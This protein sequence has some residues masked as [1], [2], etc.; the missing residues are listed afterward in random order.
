M[1]QYTYQN[2]TLS[3]ELKRTRRKNL[4]VYVYPGRRV[5]LRVP[6]AA[7]QRHIE[8]YLQQSGAWIF[9][10]LDQLDAEGAGEVEV[11]SFAQGSQHFLHGQPYALEL[12][13]AARPQRIVRVGN[14][15][16]VFSLNPEEPQRTQALLKSWYKTQA[17]PWFQQRL[18]HNW[19]AMAEFDLPQPDLR[20]RWMK[21][22]WG[23]CSR[24]AV[25]TLN[26]ELIK[27]DTALLDYVI[28][29]E[30]CHLREF[31]HSPRFY[32]MM[33]KAMP[34]WRHRKQALEAGLSQR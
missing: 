34:D 21:A 30:L 29:H 24:R 15:L 5:Q 7:R 4:A 25:I 10:Q 6:Y 33:D 32:Q 27:Y 17:A 16:Q 2:R 23:S 1:Y 18:M 12:H 22:R 3:Y 9:A 8:Q 14:V 19:Q 20:L 28:T 26:V 31:N 13:R 11:T